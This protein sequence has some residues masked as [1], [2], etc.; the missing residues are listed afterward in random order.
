MRLNFRT[1][2]KPLVSLIILIAVSTAAFA[3]PGKGLDPEKA[4]KIEAAKRTYITLKLDLTT[5]E[6]ETFWPVY[7]EYQ[8][9]LMAARTDMMGEGKRNLVI[10][11][12]TDEE[13]EEALLNQL[14]FEQ[15]VL[16][17]KSAYI[18]KF[19]E[20]ISVRK[21]Y[22][23]FKAERDFQKEMLKQFQQG[24]GKG[25]GGQMGSPDSAD[26]TE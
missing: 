25:K 21:V 20:V 1:I 11:D 12:M 16:D 9:E 7:N 5:E 15:E 14:A 8:D 18:T 2:T 19:Q 24:K 22:Q 13:I 10:D 26:D 4:E 23:L 17:I 6:A 3:Q